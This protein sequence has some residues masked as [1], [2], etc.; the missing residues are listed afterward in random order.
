MIRNMKKTCKHLFIKSNTFAF[1]LIELVCN[2]VVSFS[3][4]LL[5][6]AGM[7]QIHN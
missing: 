5:H 6:I 3:S 4:S 1:K 2:S 7:S